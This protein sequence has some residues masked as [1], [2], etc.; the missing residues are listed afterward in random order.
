[1]VPIGV[2]SVKNN[3]PEYT[4]SRTSIFLSAFGI[5]NYKAESDKRYNDAI[6]N[7]DDGIKKSEK[8]ITQSEYLLRK[9]N[10]RA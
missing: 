3:T 9:F 6:K 2:C 10:S 7:A 4:W 1:M 5:G 8:A